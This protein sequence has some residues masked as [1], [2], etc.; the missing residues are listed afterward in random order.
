[1]IE[2]L[3]ITDDKKNSKTIKH[4][5]ISGGGHYGFYTY[6]LLREGNLKGFWKLENIQTMY[7]TS[8]GALL[9]VI[10][11]LNYKWDV[12][13]NY[14]INRP[15]QNVFNADIYSLINVFHTKGIFDIETIKET[16]IP[17][18]NGA[19]QPMDINITMKEF[20]EI[21]K[22]DLH[23]FVTDLNTFNCVDISHTTHP[24]YSLIECVYCSCA[25]PIVFSP[26]YIGNECNI[27][28]CFSAHYPINY[29]I[30]NNKNIDKDEILGICK[31]ADFA[32]SSEPLNN[33][34][35][36]FDY[37]M[38]VVNKILKSIINSDYQVSQYIIK[39]QFIIKTDSLSIS[40]ILEIINSSK[41][42]EEMIKSGA[43][44]FNKKILGEDASNELVK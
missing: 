13:D 12:L 42:R 39:N 15:W 9:C 33:K 2:E 30:Q 7:G 10:L 41:V 26:F 3:A 44:I 32:A 17:L 34:K 1:M 20:Y 11:C 24:D 22:I 25:I 8:V 35:T 37:L 27:D 14:I 29:C 21:T 6:G 40:N 4:I 16:F 38:I 36:F 23:I 31:M 43:D 5:V 19:D 18:F 28:G